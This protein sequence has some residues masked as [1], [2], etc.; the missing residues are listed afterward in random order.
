MSASLHA[1]IPA[2]GAGTRLWPLS[3]EG[4]P[5]FLLDPAGTGMSLLQETVVRLQPIAESITV[6]TGRKHYE[7]V[8]EQLAHVRGKQPVP[9]EIV[10]EPSPRNSMAAIGLAAYIIRDRHGDRAVVGSFAADHAV[11][12]AGEFRAAV[13]TAVSGA[14]RGYLTTVGI[15]PTEP[16]TAFGYIAAGTPP[17]AKDLYPVDAFVEKPDPD[18]ARSYIERGY[19]WNAGIFVVEASV[20]AS[21]LKAYLPQ[22]DA[23]LSHLADSYLTAGGQVPQSERV[24]KEPWN[25]L[26]SIAIDY[27]LAEPLAAAGNVAVARAHPDLGWS[28]VGDF[29]TFS[30]L[31][32]GTGAEDLLVVDADE[33]ILLRSK[34]A[35]AGKVVAVLGADDLI[36]VDSQ[37]A[38]LITTRAHS[39]R[40][41]EVV[42]SLRGAGRGDLL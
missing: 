42:A 18:T 37:D 26:Q 13:T 34:D 24:P 35:P 17:L 2:G 21:H 15:A 12:N 25:R 29:H 23:E 7:A 38:L 10:V 33:T 11:K 40:V 28:D 41:G 6:V 9:T 27:A 4:H 30:A 20:L 32:S 1:I 14:K 5:K 3:R 16:S 39:Q 19:L 8:R 36:V 22:M 31:G